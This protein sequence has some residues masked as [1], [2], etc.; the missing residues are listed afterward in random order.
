MQAANSI[1]A[2][3]VGA[4]MSTATTLEVGVEPLLISQLEHVTAAIDERKKTLN[5]A[6]VI[7]N[8]FREK[9][10]RAVKTHA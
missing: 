10:R 8:N 5:A 6:E 9:Q 4:S 2:K 7:Y 3:T 1:I